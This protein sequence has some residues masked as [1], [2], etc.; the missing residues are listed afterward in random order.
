MDSGI[1]AWILVPYIPLPAIR[2]PPKTSARH[3]LARLSPNFASDHL[4]VVQTPG[5]AAAFGDG[6][7]L[8][9]HI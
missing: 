3:C 6:R 1:T 9:K 2:L 7:L 8:V 5:P 4:A